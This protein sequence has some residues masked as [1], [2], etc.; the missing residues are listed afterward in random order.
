MSVAEPSHR[1]GKTRT[2]ET[3]TFGVPSL[4]DGARMWRLAHASGTLDLNSPYTYLLAASHFA[5]TSV[6]ASDS[7][8]AADGGADL[9]G[10]VFGYLRPDAPD[11]VF[12]W[13]VAVADSH[14]GRGLGGGML[15]ALV[16]RLAP[17][18][19]RYLECSIT[20]DNLAS[21]A[22]FASFARDRGASL[23][24]GEVLFAASDFPTA[25][26]HEPELLCRIGPLSGPTNDHI[27]RTAPGGESRGAPLD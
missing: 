9:A 26:A 15:S 18:G 19:C 27:G 24:T 2:S 17:T 8:E 4:P 13:Q 1:V 21:H 14:R 25:A 12:V 3:V 6:V 16:D 22:L 7:A 10:F 11:T 23:T 5:D 20:P